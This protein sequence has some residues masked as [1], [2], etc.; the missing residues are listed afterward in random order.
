MASRS[1]PWAVPDYRVAAEEARRSSA[2]APFCSAVRIYGLNGS[3]TGLEP[4]SR[5]LRHRRGGRVLG[6]GGLRRRGGARAAPRPANANVPAGRPP[7][8][9]RVRGLVGAGARRR[10][11]EDRRPTPRRGAAPLEAVASASVRVHLVVPRSFNDAQSI[12]DKF[13]DAVPVILNLQGT[14]VEL[15]KRLI[16]FE[17]P[18]LCPERR[19]AAGRRQGLPPHAAERRGLGGG[20][21][22]PHRA[23]L[24]QP[25]LAR[26]PSDRVPFLHSSGRTGGHREGLRLRPF[27]RL[28]HLH[29]RLHHHVLDPASTTSRS[30]GSSASSTTSSIRTCGS[31]AVSSRSFASAASASTS[32]RSSPSSFS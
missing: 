32:R 27:A 9:G 17:R 11:G 28:P 25:E 30:T 29:H 23:R 21:G 3:G 1:C 5:L 20:A 16:D 24:L 22:P 14:D 26:P 19:D 10:R 31:S 8:P 2:W 4:C 7:L 12:A 15:S 13:K 6:R 18:H